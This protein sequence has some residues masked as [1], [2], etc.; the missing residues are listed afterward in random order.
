MKLIEKSDSSVSNIPSYLNNSLLRFKIQ[1]HFSKAKQ[2]FSTLKV[3]Q[4]CHRKTKT[5]QDQN[6]DENPNDNR[7]DSKIKTIKQVLRQ[8][9]NLMMRKIISKAALKENL[10]N[11]MFCR[12]TELAWLFPLEG[13]ADTWDKKWLT[14][15]EL[16]SMPQSLELLFLSTFVL[17]F[18]I[19]VEISV[20]KAKKYEKNFLI[21]YSF[22]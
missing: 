3:F 19:W 21:I 15:S 11:S 20:C 10:V 2:V 13:L 7:R 6:L 22:I 18:L 8:E 5:N 4:Q 17:R 9:L 14:K 1:I 12:V 16:P